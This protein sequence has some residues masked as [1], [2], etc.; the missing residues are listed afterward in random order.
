MAE[1]VLL[2]E[3]HDRVLLLRLNRP[4]RL[5]AIDDA[6]LE[7][8]HDA[9]TEVGSSPEVDALVLTGSG[10]A[11]CAGGDVETLTR[12]QDLATPQR[13]ARFALG[14]E[15]ALRIAGLPVPVV[16][17]VNGAAAGA[18]L[19]LALGADLC[20]AAPRASFGSGFVA[21]G[22]V[23][24]LGGSWL[25]PRVVGLSRA[26]QLVLGPE[27]LDA[28]TAR[29]WGIVSR[30]VD[31]VEESALAAAT[32]LAGGS[33]PAYAE[34]KR[35]LLDS[36]RSLDESLTVGALTQSVL[37]DTTEHRRRAELFR[38]RSPR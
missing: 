10:R 5:N 30:V 27:R 38:A 17:A 3:W 11:F 8:L 37:M 16:A 24:D 19:D 22:L 15:L 23:P 14:A 1:D 31:D 25:L 13:R 26:R 35:A 12:W 36:G 29:Q 2:R 6:L 21:M 33:R 20:L 18:G 34:A 9:V 4:E 7:A 28:E 32:T